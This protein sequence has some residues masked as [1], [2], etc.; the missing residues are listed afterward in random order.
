MSLPWLP[1]GIVVTYTRSNDDRVRASII[2]AWASGQYMSIEHDAEGQ[3]VSHPTAPAHRIEDCA[4][5]HQSL[6]FRNEYVR[7]GGGGVWV[8]PHRAAYS[9]WI[10]P[11][12]NF[13]SR[14]FGWV[15][16]RAKGPPALL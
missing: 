13:G 9:N 1:T 14:F 6:F 10:F 11:Q 12:P 4:R 2:S 15:G 3:R 7:A 5:S 8:D 16:L